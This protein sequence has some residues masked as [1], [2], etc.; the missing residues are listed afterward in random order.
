M[1]DKKRGPHADFI[2]SLKKETKTISLFIW[3]Q[4][5]LYP[6]NEWECEGY[7]EYDSMGVP[8]FVEIRRK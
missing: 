1:R 5:Y 8:K 3:E 7:S 4:N 2:E 6:H